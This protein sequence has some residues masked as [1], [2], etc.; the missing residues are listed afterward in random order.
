[1]GRFRERFN[2]PR[3]HPHKQ[4]SVQTPYRG[5]Y[6]AMSPDDTLYR[7]GNLQVPGKGH[8]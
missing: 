4:V 5:R 8:A 7:H 3:C 1:M 2:F 6:S